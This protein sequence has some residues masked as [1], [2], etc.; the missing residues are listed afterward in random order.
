MRTQACRLHDLITDRDTPP[1]ATSPDEGARIISIVSGKGGVGKTNLALNGGIV[2]AQD[3][4][5]VLIVDG[6]MS[7]ANISV[8]SGEMSNGSLADIGRG[9]RSPE[10]AIAAGP[11]GVRMALAGPADPEN[12][13]DQW[14]WVLRDIRRGIQSVRASYDWIIIDTGPGIADDTMDIIE[15]SDSILV[16]STMEP[17][18]LTNTFLLIKHIL[19]RHPAIPCSIVINGVHAEEDAIEALT[20]L[21]NAVQHFLQRDLPGAGWIF[22][23]ADIPRA[24]CRQE[25]FILAFPESDTADGIRKLIRT[26]MQNTSSPAELINRAI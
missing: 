1:A 22:W 2:I 21:N 23:D 7:A 19:K 13:R 4:H 5:D 25:P 11:A 24:V 15:I 8:L 26:V 17:T 9:R 14:P 20:K 3:K 18:A 16:L 6:D 12:T 10:E